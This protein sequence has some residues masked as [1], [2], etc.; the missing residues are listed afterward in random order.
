MIDLSRLNQFLRIEIKFQMEAQESIM[1]SLNT[2]EWVSSVDLQDACLHIPIH[3]RSKVSEVCLQISNL[4]IHLSS[5]RAS[6]GCSNVHCDSEGSKTHDPV[7][8]DWLIRAQ[9]PREA[10]H[11]TKVVVNLTESLGQ[12][13]NQDKSELTPTQV[14]SFVGYKYHLNLALGK[15]LNLGEVAKM[16]DINP[17]DKQSA[18]TTR[19]SLSLIG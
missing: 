14:F 3:S 4:P 10:S 17:E 2:V 1:I 12:T 9:S 16:T 18:L 6:P 15:P 11:N 7:M 5:V 19:C 13:I 8:D